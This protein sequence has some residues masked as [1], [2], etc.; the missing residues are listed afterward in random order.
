MKYSLKTKIIT[1]YLG[2]QILLLIYLAFNFILLCFTLWILY[3]LGSESLYNSS[4]LTIK[5]IVVY[6]LIVTGYILGY[7]II[8][9]S[10]QATKKVLKNLPLR[11]S[12]KI[13]LFTAPFV[14]IA[15]IAAITALFPII[16]ILF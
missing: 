7:Y 4:I 9:K 13:M 14:I 10:T 11:K 6:F 2:F 12:E 16:K 15:N 1:I 3:G 5:I 8:F